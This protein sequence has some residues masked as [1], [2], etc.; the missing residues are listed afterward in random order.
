M[1]IFAL[2]QQKHADLLPYKGQFMSVYR[3]QRMD[4]LFG[5]IVCN[6]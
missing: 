2:K 6:L 3:V 4:N 5:I 1:Q